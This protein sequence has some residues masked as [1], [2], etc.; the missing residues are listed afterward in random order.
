[1][2]LPPLPRSTLFALACA[3]GSTQASADDDSTRVYRVADVVISAT[4]LDLPVTES[5]S[6]C[7]IIPVA[8]DRLVLGTT[9][10][11]ILRTVVGVT[12]RDNGPNGQLKTVSLRG[13]SAENVLILLDG[14]RLNSMQNGL[15]DLSL[16]PLDHLDRIELVRGGIPRWNFVRTVTN[17]SVS[18]HSH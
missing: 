9:A 11:D 18:F 4:R 5:P 17:Y 14:V 13:L 16:V 8:Q 2:H 1:M 6:S 10:A 12:L 15:A 3:I 7:S